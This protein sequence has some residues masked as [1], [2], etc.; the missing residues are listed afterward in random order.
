MMVLFYTAEHKYAIVA[1]SLPSPEIFTFHSGDLIIGRIHQE[2]GEL[3]RI[4]DM[5]SA[6]WCAS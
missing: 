2:Y 6:D 5:R 4:G 1:Y 3:Q